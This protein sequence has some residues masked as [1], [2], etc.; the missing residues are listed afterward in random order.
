MSL[1]LVAVNGQPR[2]YCISFSL[3]RAAHQFTTVDGGD[4]TYE[5]QRLS[6]RTSSAC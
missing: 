2:K 4:V 1:R 5:I 3:D 6:R